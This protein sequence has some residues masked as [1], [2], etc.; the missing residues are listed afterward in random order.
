MAIELKNYDPALM[1][2]ANIGVSVD[3][4]DIV[5]MNGNEVIEIDGVADA[6]NFLRVSNSATSS[7]VVLSARGDDTN[8][9][10]TINSLLTGALT[11]DST[12]T[13][14]V[15]IGNSANAK[16]ITIG[17]TTG[18]TA[19]AIKSGSGGT[20]V[21]SADDNAFTVGANGA[22]NPLVQVD[23]STAS[24][25]TGIKIT[26]AAAASGLAVAVI[27]S[28]TNENLTVDA[29]GSG[30][31]SL[32]VTGTGNIVLGRAATGV[33]LS[34]TGAAT[35]KSATA[36]PATAGA[37]AAGAALVWYSTSLTV[38]VTSDAPT[39]TRPKGSICINTGGTTTSTRMYVNTDGAGTWASFTT[40]A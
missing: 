14:A 16:T 28:G 34:V 3:L 19:V 33:S 12:S 35:L 27:S 20:V 13:G 26:G 7:A 24:V 18:A 30:T 1:Q 39:H 32:N 2:G 5:D 11:L 31:I 17:N 23:A 21:T 40:S 25:A 4:T 29:K 10:L 8:I 22:T 6:V 9:D 37:V 36:I 15:N 38:E